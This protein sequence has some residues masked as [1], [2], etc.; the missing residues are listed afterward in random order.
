MDSDDDVVKHDDD[1]VNNF[2]DDVVSNDGDSCD[3]D[4]SEVLLSGDNRACSCFGG[5]SDCVAVNDN[6][7]ETL[8]GLQLVTVDACTVHGGV[9]DDGFDDNAFVDRSFVDVGV[10]DVDVV[11]EGESFN[12]DDDCHDALLNDSGDNGVVNNGDGDD[13][14]VADG[15]VVSATPTSD[16]CDN[17]VAPAAPTFR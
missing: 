5:H 13:S 15:S 6:D 3:V 4:C 8:S 11:C 10:G 14:V 12:D 7:D 16:T 9:D 2:D 1:V 17:D